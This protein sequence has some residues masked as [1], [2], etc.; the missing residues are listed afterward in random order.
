MSA[1][2][3]FATGPI[4]PGNYVVQFKGKD[5]A[6]DDAAYAIVVGAGR[7]KV[8]AYSVRGDKF[9]SGG[10]AMRV[11][12]PAGT[13]ISGQVAEGAANA[14]GARFANGRRYV[15][16]Y[17]PI[18]SNVGPRWVEEGTPPSWNVVRYSND[19]MRE[20]QD[21]GAGMARRNGR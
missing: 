20:L 17:A 14:L 8:V 13:R 6:N 1:D 2:G 7:H 19:T 11:K 12:A 3:T 15:L 5:A 18:G 21:R 9:A 16:A 4:A 10:I